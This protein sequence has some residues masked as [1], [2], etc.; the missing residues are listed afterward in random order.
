MQTLL[1]QGLDSLN[2]ALWRR[3]PGRSRANAS[4]M[5]GSANGKG[6]G[7]GVPNGKTHDVE[8]TADESDQN[9]STDVS[10]DFLPEPLTVELPPA[11]ARVLELTAACMRF[12][13]S[14]YRVPLD[15]TSD[16][17]SLVD[18][19][20]RDA[21]KEIVL[22]PA[23]MELISLSIGAYLGEVVRRTFGAEWDVT[24]EESTYRLCF[25][26]VYLWTNPM[27]MGREALTMVTEDGWNAHLSTRADD[28]E[29]L[30]ARLESLPQVD[31]DE[32][33]LPTTRY[34]SIHIAFEGLRS[35]AIE[36]GQGEARFSL[37]DYR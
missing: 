17:L 32:F 34:D 6:S 30:T 5:S 14:K 3:V 8:L 10:E 27:G 35:R 36:K 26:S 2:T 31:E 9:S 37:A 16:T 33:Y 15:F 20:V 21:R 29:A 12:V 7:N 25:A 1:S 13:E 23:S 24:G 4:L 28:R 19:Y 22:L 18:Q 11:P